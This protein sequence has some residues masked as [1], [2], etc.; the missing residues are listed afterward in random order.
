M[1]DE[2]IYKERTIT[3]NKFKPN[4]YSLWVIQAKAMF[5]ASKC[6]GFAEGTKVN[7]TP[8]GVDGAPP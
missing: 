2:Q 3:L 4:E 5:K 7:A 6:L 8:P 1:A